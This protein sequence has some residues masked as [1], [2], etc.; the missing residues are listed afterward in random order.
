MNINYVWMVNKFPERISLSLFYRIKAKP[1]S[2]T[3][4]VRARVTTTEKRTLTM[5]VRIFLIQPNWLFL[6]YSMR[7]SAQVRFLSLSLQ[8]LS[9]FINKYIEKEYW[10]RRD[11]IKKTLLSYLF[12]WG[13]DLLLHYLFNCSVH[14][15]LRHEKKVAH[16]LLMRSNLFQ[17]K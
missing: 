6:S 16:H 4:A 2:K 10:R 3:T 7:I 15:T 14:V 13:E 12:N 17:Q 5:F 11:N 9:R 1:K 8:T